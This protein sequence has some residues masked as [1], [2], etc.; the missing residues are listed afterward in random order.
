M[1]LRNRVGCAIRNHVWEHREVDEWVV[2]TCQRCGTVSELPASE[3]SM[4]EASLDGD[5]GRGMP[6][7]SMGFFQ[8]FGSGDGGGDF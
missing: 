1:N 7:L 8:D 2:S 4:G 6:G 5:A 3:Y